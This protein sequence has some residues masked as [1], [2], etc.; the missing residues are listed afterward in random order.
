MPRTKFSTAPIAAAK[1]NNLKRELIVLD[2]TA[3][4]AIALG[5]LTRNVFA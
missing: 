1:H 4:D 2:F 3:H 5:R